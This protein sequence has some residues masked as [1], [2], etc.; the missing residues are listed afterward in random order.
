MKTFSNAL[1]TAATSLIDQWV[2]REACKAAKR[3]ASFSIA[4]IEEHIRD[5]QVDSI[6]R[7]FDPS[8][9]KLDWVE[10][11][12]EPETECVGFGQFIFGQSAA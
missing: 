6:W 9:K 12:E 5:E 10:T 1:I 11:Q 2:I 3:K 8:A 7:M 4:A